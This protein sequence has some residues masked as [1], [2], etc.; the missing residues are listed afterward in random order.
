MINSG[1]YLGAFGG[2]RSTSFIKV[3]L[4]PRGMPC[5]NLLLYHLPHCTGSERG[6]KGKVC[7]SSA[8]NTCLHLVV[9]ALLSL[10]RI[11]PTGIT[12]LPK[13]GF[14]MRNHFKAKKHQD[15]SWSTFPLQRI[16]GRNLCKEDKI[17]T[18]SPPLPLQP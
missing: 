6:L 11:S 3:L 13:L 7:I 12:T 18:L 10:S 9:N 2:N 5:L 14:Q 16:R 4:L 15:A 1:L 17:Y 8:Q